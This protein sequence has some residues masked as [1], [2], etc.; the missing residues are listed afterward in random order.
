MDNKKEENGSNTAG[1]K[2]KSKVKNESN[3][4]EDCGQWDEKEHKAIFVLYIF[5]F[6]LHI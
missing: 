6:T 5:N 4:V 3:I 2:C 1:S